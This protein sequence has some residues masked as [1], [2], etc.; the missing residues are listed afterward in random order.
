MYKI[1]QIMN[2]TQTHI[3]EADSFDVQNYGRGMNLISRRAEET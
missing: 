3:K 2:Y 1:T